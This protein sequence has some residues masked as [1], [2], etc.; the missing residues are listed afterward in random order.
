MEKQQCP[1]TVFVSILPLVQLNFQM[2][3]I[4]NIVEY[5]NKELFVS[6][7]R[8]IIIFN[9]NLFIP[10]LAPL[11]GNF[12]ICDHTVAFLSIL[13]L[14]QLNFQLSQISNM[15]EYIN[16]E[17]FVS[18]C[19]YII[20]FDYNLFIPVIAPIDDNLEIHTHIN[21]DTCFFMY[22]R[23]FCIKIFLC[24]TIF[25]RQLFF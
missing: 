9:C 6:I 7:C 17:L 2:F 25:M 1:T 19:R 16:K 12:D 23:I 8:C 13:P 21:M 11:Q 18:I 14:V 22:H 4:S 3:L 10:S 5:I 20:N 15:V 24:I